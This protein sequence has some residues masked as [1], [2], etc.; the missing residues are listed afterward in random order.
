MPRIECPGCGAVT[1]VGVVRHTADE[2]C[3]SC[4][5]PLFWAARDGPD[6][7]ADG[8]GEDEVV[9]AVVRRRPGTGGRLV[10]EGTPCP[11]CNE[12]NAP[13]NVYCQRCGAP[14]HPPPPPP[15]TPAVEEAPAP[16]PVPPAPEA[17][18]A[19]ETW[20]VV[21]VVALATVLLVQLV[22]LILNEIYGI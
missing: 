12:L 18:P 10:L 21:A 8:A 19:R 20:I 11:A 1:D 6:L 4:D 22:V 3:T 9:A 16:A 17:P 13:R 15:P 14:M 7:A 2:F 5:F